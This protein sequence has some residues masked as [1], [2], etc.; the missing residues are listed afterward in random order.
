M[1]SRECSSSN[2][3][4]VANSHFDRLS[5]LDVLVFS[6]E[7]GYYRRYSPR[8]FVGFSQLKITSPSNLESRRFLAARPRTKRPAFITKLH[9]H[10]NNVMNLWRHGS[11]FS[12]SFMTKKTYY[13]STCMVLMVIGVAGCTCYFA[14]LVVLNIQ[15][16]PLIPPRR[17][18]PHPPS[19]SH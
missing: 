5:E 6:P 18:G 9:R 19:T 12:S 11:H 4:I 17:P 13:I 14:F 7:L 8:K 15:I 1:K 3:C 16:T 10:F 2:F